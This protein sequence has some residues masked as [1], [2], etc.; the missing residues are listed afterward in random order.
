M[1]C[2]NKIIKLE[3]KLVKIFCKLK[4]KLIDSVVISYCSLFYDILR[5]LSVVIF[6]IVVMR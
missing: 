6:L 3:I 5:E 4:F 1:G 2:L